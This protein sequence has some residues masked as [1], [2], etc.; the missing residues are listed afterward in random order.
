MRRRRRLTAAVLLAAASTG[1]GSLA[2][3]SATPQEGGTV[4]ADVDGDAKPNAVAVR[5]IAPAVHELSVH[6]GGRALRATFPTGGTVPLQ[7][8]RAVDI[9]GDGRAELLVAHGADARTGTFNVWKYDPA[10]GLVRMA[11][12]NGTPFDVTEGSGLS[13]VHGYS[14]APDPPR[15]RELV[16]V[17]VELTS[18]PGET[19]AYTGTRINYAVD[20]DVIRPVFRKDITNEPRI[21]SLLITNPSSCA[22]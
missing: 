3:A 20:G 16:T 5:E 14:C 15:P 13:E 6:A 21:H 4:Q 19:T 18:A 22:A 2:P 9:D 10:R 8:P 7:Q 1:A 17:N 12:A 11:A